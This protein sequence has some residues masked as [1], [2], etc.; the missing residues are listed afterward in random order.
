[1]LHP[2]RLIDLVLA[3]HFHSSLVGIK[4]LFAND[5]FIV[6]IRIKRQ[7]EKML[8][9]ECYLEVFLKQHHQSPISQSGL[10]FNKNEWTFSLLCLNKM[11]LFCFCRWDNI[12]CNVI[13]KEAKSLESDGV[14]DG[15]S[16]FKWAMH[17]WISLW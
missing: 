6:G 2:I 10:W 7:S 4:I 17:A 3:Q 14:V 11:S 8:F 1:M 13:F 15:P 5:L 16:T 9:K 12:R